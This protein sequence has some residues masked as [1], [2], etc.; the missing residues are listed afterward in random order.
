MCHSIMQCSI[1]CC[2]SVLFGEVVD[3]EVKAV[4]SKG[5]QAVGWE[6]KKPELQ[7]MVISKLQG[8]MLDARDYS[9]DYNR[10][11]DARVALLNIGDD[12]TIKDTIRRY[13]RNYFDRRNM[14]KVIESTT[15]PLLIPLLAE[16]LAS[17][18]PANS[19]KREGEVIV[20]PRSVTSSA[21]IC[22]L[23]ENIPNIN[24]EV[25]KW[26]RQ[27]SPRKPEEL[28]EQVRIFWKENER[29]FMKEDYAAV[30]VPE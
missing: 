29:A 11:R 14:A 30:L 23:L 21:V 22:K 4:L 26:A 12:F 17:S 10:Q 5:L 19:L 25:K 28:L 18:E 20:G 1:G 15:Q 16:D 6:S 24:L 8:I 3:D 13:R 9:R 27:T 2:T 7:S